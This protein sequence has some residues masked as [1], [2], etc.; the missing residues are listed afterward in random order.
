MRSATTEATK[1]KST[2]E[3]LGFTAVAADPSGEDVV[4]GGGLV[5]AEVAGGGA[6]VT[7]GTA[8]GAGALPGGKLVGVKSTE[9]VQRKSVRKVLTKFQ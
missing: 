9:P 7:G 1:T 3:M 8:E 4:G 5:V 6:V 2:D